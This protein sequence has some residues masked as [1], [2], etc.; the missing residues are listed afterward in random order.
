MMTKQFTFPFIIFYP[1]TS[2]DGM[3]FP[4]NK[5]IYEYQGAEV[6]GCHPWCG[7]IIVSK[8]SDRSNP[9]NS[10]RDV[11]MA[12][13]PIVKNIFRCNVSPQDQ[14]KSSSSQS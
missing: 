1:V 5:N 14:P 4:V 12:D 8:F 7:D 3:P 2:R 9:M 10:L 11:S 6:R 13:F